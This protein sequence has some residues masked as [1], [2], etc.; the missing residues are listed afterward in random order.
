[1]AAYRPVPRG[2]AAAFLGGAVGYLGFE[3]VTQFSS[4][5]C[6]ARRR[7]ISTCRTRYFF[8]TDTLLIFDHLERRIKIV[9]NARVTDP[10]SADRAY[11]EAVAKI[12]ELEAR[13]ERPV[14][15]RLL[16]SLPRW[17]RWSRRQHDAATST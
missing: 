8:V 12:E 1:M 15:A 6:R 13:L 14:R 7:T 9:A 3:A 17:R 11:D 5:R 10:T 16:P 2:R 4:R